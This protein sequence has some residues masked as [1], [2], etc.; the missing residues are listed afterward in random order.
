[1]T[2]GRRSCRRERFGEAGE[3][4]KKKKEGRDTADPKAACEDHTRRQDPEPKKLRIKKEE[5]RMSGQVQGHR[6]V[7]WFLVCYRIYDEVGQIL[8][9]VDRESGP[10]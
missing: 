9:A 7:V 10:G 4:E 8:I 6:F 2:D 5:G 1:M 3:E